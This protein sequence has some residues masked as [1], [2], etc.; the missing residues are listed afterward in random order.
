MAFLK[1]VRLHF[2][3]SFCKFGWRIVTHLHVNNLLK[4]KVE[5]PKIVTLSNSTT[6]YL[7]WHVNYGTWWRNWEG[8]SF[9]LF[10]LM[11]FLVRCMHLNVCLPKETSSGEYNLCTEGNSVHSQISI[12][13]MSGGFWFVSYMPILLCNVVS[14]PDEVQMVDGTRDMGACRDLVWSQGRGRGLVCN[15]VACCIRLGC[16]LLDVFGVHSSPISVPHDSLQSH[17]NSA[18]LHWCKYLYYATISFCC[19]GF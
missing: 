4:H 3:M 15:L 13:L 6:M 9:R 19:G 17:V 7:W 5:Q 12:L 18:A 8:G 10:Y 11:A 14:V 1:H 16:H 2:S